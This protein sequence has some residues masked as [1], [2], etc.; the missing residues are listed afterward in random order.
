MQGRHAQGRAWLEERHPAWAVENGFSV[1]QWWHLALFQLEMLATGEALA[2]YDAQLG[3]DATTL[4]LQWLD[5]ASLLWRIQLLGVDVGARWAALAASWADPVAH[6]GFYAFNDVHAALA[7]I[8][9]RDF[10]RAQ[11][12][13]DRALPAQGDN[14]AMASEVGVPLVQALLDHAQGR[15]DAAATALYGLRTRAHRFGGSHAQ[16]DLI[17]Q[18][19]LA[20][21]ARGSRKDLGRALLNERCLAKPHTPLTAHWASRLGIALPVTR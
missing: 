13:L 20:A 14:R 6:A 17:D 18:T 9:S 2:L 8:G 5:A 16:R 3:S 19:A 4:N 10:A 12:L 1:H 7:L 21:C 11:T 15:H